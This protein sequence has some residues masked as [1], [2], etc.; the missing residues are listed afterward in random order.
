MNALLRQPVWRLIDQSSLG[1]AFDA[2]QSFAMDDT[3]CRSVG[4]GESPAAARLWVHQKTVVLG[5]QDTRLPHLGDALHILQDA[6][7]RW[8]VRNSGGLAVVLDDGV[9][10]LSLIFS[11]KK[12]P[13]TIDVVFEAMVDFVKIVLAPLGQQIDVGEIAGSYCPGRYDLSVD[14]RK[15]AGMSQRRVRDGAAVQVY[16]CVNGNGAAR[17][18]LIRNFYRRGIQGA[19]T[20][21]DYPDIDPSLMASLSEIC[22]QDLTAAMLRHAVIQ[23]LQTFGS[24]SASDL[25]TAESNVFGYYYERMLRRNDRAFRSMT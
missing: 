25:S 18:R 24:V 2:R 6:G 21:F 4:S 22:G 8:V 14:G 11:E 10:N 16:L 5:I 3:L 23:T 9:L 12:C 19:S 17:A 20:T 7:Y 13:L 15:F 1:D